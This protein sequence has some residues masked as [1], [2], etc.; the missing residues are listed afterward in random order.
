MPWNPLGSWESLVVSIGTGIL[1]GL[2]LLTLQWSWN[3]LAKQRRRRDTIEALGKFFQDWESEVTATAHNEDWQFVRHEQ[4]MSRMKDNLV[5]MHPT[6]SECQ[7]SDIN[8]LIRKHEELID[9]RRRLVWPALSPVNVP[10]SPGLILLPGE[11]SEFFD[12]AKAIKW[13]KIS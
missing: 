5:L 6:L 8:E 11:Y 9:E 1:A 2:A 12:Q 3:N 4:I 13:L 10:V 7:W